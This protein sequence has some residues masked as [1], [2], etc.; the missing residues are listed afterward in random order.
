MKRLKICHIPSKAD[1]DKQDRFK[2]EK[3]ATHF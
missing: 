2:K 1:P 3:N